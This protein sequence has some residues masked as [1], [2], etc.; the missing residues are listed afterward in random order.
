MKSGDLLASK[1]RIGQR[2]GEGAMGEVWSGENLA[3]G[4]KV[5]LKLIIRS[6]AKNTS[7]ELRQ[8]LLREARACGKLEHRNIVQIYDVGETPEGD[9]FLV[10]ELLRGRT[11]AERLKDTRR[12]EPQM[13][14]R[15]GADIANALAVAHAAKIIHRDLKPANI[16]LHQ[17]EVGSDER[18]VVKILDF[19]VSKNLD[20]HG[21]GPATLTNQAL[22]SPVYMSPE[23]IAVQKDLDGRTDIWSL[24]IVLYEM[25]TGGRPFVGSVNDVVQQ[26]VLTRVNKVPAPS[27]K[28]RDVSPEFDALVGRC[29][30]N[31]RALRYADAA[32][33]SRAL[34]AIAEAGAPGRVSR[35]SS[36]PAWAEGKQLET[37]TATP[38]PEP[39]VERAPTPK[40]VEA[41]GPS[42]TQIISA[43]DVVA[44][45]GPTWRKEMQEWRA[46]REAIATRLMGIDEVH[47][48]TQ[49]IDASP[50]F[51]VTN[52]GE[53][54]GTTSGL[55][56]LSRPN[57]E[58]GSFDGT[59]ARIAKRKRNTRQRLAIMV[60]GLVSA[61]VLLAVLVHIAQSDGETIGPMKKEAIVPPL[62]SVLMPSASAIAPNVPVEPSPKP[63]PT[64]VEVTP[65]PVKSAPAPVVQRVPA[66][67]TGAKPPG[68]APVV[69]TCAKTS[70]G[71]TKTCTTT[72]RTRLFNYYS[73]NKL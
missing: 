62:S 23:Q 42:G 8:R 4:R 25:L 49:A 9:P 1:Y 50:V 34:L 15:I 61:L 19:G 18:F 22:G 72:K 2:I 55:G 3:T 29:L 27:I 65:E 7:L 67:S 58:P 44:S 69:T 39:S 14:A 13:A 5:A 38:T 54:S 31:D 26:I 28:V 43:K 36:R 46:Q 30:E 17:E 66:K 11:L 60:T 20:G 52:P 24:G 48:G 71:T 68:S 56:A 12:I 21:D 63:A 73:P 70:G 32:E 47:G 35:S 33:V 6:A 57:F 16:F 10:L 40:P 59:A 51:G 41:R 37:E 53:S 64:S 45:P